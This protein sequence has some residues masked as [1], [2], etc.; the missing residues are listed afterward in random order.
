MS[1]RPKKQRTRMP[2][3]RLLYHFSSNCVFTFGNIYDPGA[4]GR[5]VAA[6][7]SIPLRDISCVIIP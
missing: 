7:L 3:S 5:S 6:Y 2:I 1:K 4:A